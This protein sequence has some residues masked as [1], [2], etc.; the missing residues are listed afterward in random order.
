MR[1]YFRNRQVL[2]SI[3]QLDA[4]AA[5]TASEYVATS[6]T[7]LLFHFNDNVTDYSGNSKNGSASGIT[8]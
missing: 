3:R 1:D 5:P 4:V 8:Y 6:N 7:K 2:G